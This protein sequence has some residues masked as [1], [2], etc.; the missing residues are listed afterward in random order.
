MQIVASLVPSVSQTQSAARETVLLPFLMA[1]SH[2]LISLS[3]RKTTL[4]SKIKKN[5]INI[6]MAMQGLGS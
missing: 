2:T 4:T 3:Q 6:L 1:Y 5:I